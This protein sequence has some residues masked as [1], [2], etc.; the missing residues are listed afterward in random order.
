M[1][2]GI[3]GSVAQAEVERKPT[4]QQRANQQRAR[5]GQ[6]R[7]ATPRPFGWQRDRTAADPA[8]A[9]AIRDASGELL[10]GG[11]ISGVVRD[12]TARGVRPRQSASGSG[13]ATP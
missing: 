5:A 7:K 10:A 8:E 9:A 4:R 6:A 12:W 1:M 11:T 13:P 2:A 3:L